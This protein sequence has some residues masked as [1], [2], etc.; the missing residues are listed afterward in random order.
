M[1]LLANMTQARPGAIFG[2]AN[3]EYRYLLTR[4]W[5]TGKGTCC[6]IMLNPSTADETED[7]PT[8]RRCIRFAQTWNFK[9]LVVGN[10]FALRSTDP[11]AL[12]SHRDPVGPENDEYLAAL[13]VDSSM[14]ICAWGAHGGLVSRG[15]TIAAWATRLTVLHH[16]GLTKEGYPR[17][18]LYLK[19][20]LKPVEWKRDEMFRV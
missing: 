7:D 13:M 20:D 5:L 9:H 11:A 14:V 4:S 10:I 12:K 2:G 1:T 15:R 18:P 8:V 17:H 3:Q 16:L 6:F 19:G